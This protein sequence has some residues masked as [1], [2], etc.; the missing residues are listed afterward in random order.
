MMY[1]I[2]SISFDRHTIVVC[3]DGEVTTV[4]AFREQYNQ[5][6]SIPSTIFHQGDI[7]EGWCSLEGGDLVGLAVLHR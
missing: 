6:G 2:D 5:H 3:P 4:L 1:E 7:S